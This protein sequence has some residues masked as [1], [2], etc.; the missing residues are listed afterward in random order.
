MKKRTISNMTTIK[1]ET[2]NHLFNF[3]FMKIK[4]Y[5][6]L[7]KYPSTKNRTWDLSGSAFYRFLKEWLL[8]FHPNPLFVWNVHASYKLQP[9]ALATELWRVL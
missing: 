6:K 8:A 4:E 3:L 9:S 5:C 7:K 2:I 1:T